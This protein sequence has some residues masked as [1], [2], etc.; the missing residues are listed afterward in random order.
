MTGSSSRMRLTR[1]GLLGAGIAAFAAPALA[2]CSSPAVA[3]LT[4]AQLDPK[5]LVYWNLF[6]GGDGSRMQTMEAHYQQTHG[7]P[8]SLQSTVF[9]WGNPYY[10]K[11]TLA[12][13][14]NKPP[15][16]AIS[17]L[18]RAKNLA[19]A[20]IIE[21]IT[22]AELGLVG[23]SAADFNPKAWAAQR[24]G[25]HNIAIPLDTHPLVMF[26]NVDVCSKAGLIGSDG[27][28]K[29][30]HGMSEF[31]SALKAIS[32]VTGGIAASLANVAETATPWRFFTTLYHQH[33]NASP[34]LSDDGAKFTIDDG[35]AVEVMSRVASWVKQGWMNDALNYADAET[36]LFTGKAGFYFEGEWEITTA[37]GI[38]GLKFG[39]V[40]VPTLYDQPASQADS[41]T[42]VLPKKDRTPA[43][44]QQV[45]GFVK[46]MLD[47]SMTWAKG[48]H[49]PAY[50]PVRN[51][52][53]YGKLEPQ[54]DY[55]SAANDAVYDDPAWYSGSGS[56]FENIIGAQLA[57]AQQRA[58][59]PKAAL[60]A[61]R[62]QLQVYLRTPSP[63]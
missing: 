63:L 20:G 27:K 24:L 42:F 30:I 38:K 21:P 54:A 17:H 5:T 62:S 31:E 18:T 59:S 6:G 46:S 25:G 15:D 33:A 11:L 43:Q 10:S 13:V 12:T 3:G 16:I 35:I 58:V 55:A 45:M 1:R 49:I 4:G 50:L 60:A 61:T 56:T 29:P 39:M 14:G 51:S 23:L 2:A 7:G 8:S 57:L 34:V 40:P 53:A 22:D 28:L 32:K 37:Q 19:Q 36:D 44:R 52:D 9:A 41:H 26:Y 48:G 47:Q